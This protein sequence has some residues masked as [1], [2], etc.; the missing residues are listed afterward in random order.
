MT[1]V[2]P[3]NTNSSGIKK[4]EED[5]VGEEAEERKGKSTANI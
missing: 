5:K 4:K 2:I 3:K 1:I